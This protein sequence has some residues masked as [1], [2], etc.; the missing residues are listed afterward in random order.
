MDT[1][2][3]TSLHAISALA[4]N[5][6]LGGAQSPCF[7]DVRKAPA[8][9]AAEFTLP[10]ALR[11][12]P[13]QVDDQLDRLRGKQVVTG[14]V[15]GHQVSQNAAQTRRDA[16]IDAPSSSTVSRAGTRPACRLS[17]S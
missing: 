12:V 3:A 4:L 15:H 2:P 8:F 14:C 17:R 13:E 7:L 9:D 6:L 10:G 11:C 16:G 1:A 5:A